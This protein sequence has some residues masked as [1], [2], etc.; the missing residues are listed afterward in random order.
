ME[1]R[2]FK[3]SERQLLLDSI[4][5]L[6]AHNHIY[7]RKPEV[8]EHLVLN[9]PYR[10]EFA[11]EDNYSFIG[12]WDDTGKV[13]GLCGAMP[14]RVNV[15]GKEYPS[16][17]VTV[18]IVDRECPTAN[19]LLLRQYAYKD[20]PAVMV[21]LGNSEINMNLHRKMHGA[22]CLDHLPRWVAFNPN[23]LED[24]RQN[25]LK[26][27]QRDIFLPTFKA[28]PRSS[29]IT[30]AEDFE[31]EEWDEFYFREFAPY[32]IGTQRDYTFLNW[33]YGES[34][35]LKY[36][37]LTAKNEA[38]KYVGGAV[39]RL[40]KILDDRFVVGRI[41]EFI[42]LDAEAS[43]ALANAIINYA[44]EALLWDFYCLS[45]ITAYGLEAVGLQKIS[46]YMNLD[47]LPTRFQPIDNV[48]INA[49]I[50]L[51]REILAQINPLDGYQWYI[52][53]GD[54]DQDRAN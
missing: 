37:I 22:F 18:W 27:E 45:A 31:R 40:E 28:V 29:R 3:K 42:T 54:N 46:P 32:M 6:W 8:L 25:L 48:Q 35:V 47:P 30:V 39:I 10:A 51:R 12:E 15:F 9:T 19:G 11:G 44:P 16:V 20:K 41:L 23:R 4:D 53:K 2:F 24:V 36:H 34:P 26:P 5:R 52:T 1:V 38:G 21:G 50:L 33:R 43:L 49:M 7:V 13:V 14:Q 17:S